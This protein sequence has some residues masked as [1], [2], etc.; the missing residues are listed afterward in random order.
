MYL[1][2]EAGVKRL[3]LCHFGAGLSRRLEEL[4]LEAVRAFGGPVEIPEE[5]REYRV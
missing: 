3:I 5:L 1:I 2:H 4:R